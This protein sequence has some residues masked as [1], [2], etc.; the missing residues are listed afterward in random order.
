MSTH[1]ETSPDAERDPDMVG[2]EAAMHRAARRARQRAQM[3]A[4]TTDV[5][6]PPGRPRGFRGARTRRDAHE[7][8]FSQAQGYEDV[9]GPLKLEELPRDARTQIWNLFFEHISRSTRTVE[10]PSFALDTN[11]LIATPWY[12]ILL[13]K[14]LRLDRGPLDE[15]DSE[16]SGIR[17]GLRE[18]VEKR[19]FNKVFDLIQFVMRHPQCPPA[20]IKQMKT[21]FADCQLAYTIDV[22]R[23]PTVI[24]AV[25]PS[26]GA[27]VVESLQQLR[28]AGLDASAAHL[29]E[30]S[31]SINASDWAGAVR[32]SIHA[33]ESVARQLDPGA[34]STLGPAL[35]SLKKRGRLHPA[36]K[37]AFGELYGYTSDEQGIRHSRLDQMKSPVG[38]DEAVFMLGACASFASYLWRKHKAGD[39]R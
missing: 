22:E 25:T 37:K 23:P 9:P 26:E 11:T 5:E 38:Q 20:F 3:A 35:D 15:W 24:P 39:S 34:S 21:T 18:Y 31:G 4:P 2:V 14:H 7:L 16:F 30:A 19:P 17:Q 29:R 33:V 10:D 12:E 32:E 13:A 6:R 1:R 27:T 28:E 36:L 8:S